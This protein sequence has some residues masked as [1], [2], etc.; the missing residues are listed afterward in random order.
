MRDYDW[1]QCASLTEIRA[2]FRTDLDP[3]LV[4]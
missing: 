4:I 1:K 2:S 3:E